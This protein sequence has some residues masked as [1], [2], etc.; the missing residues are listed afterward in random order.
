MSATIALP[1]RC[2]TS[3]APTLTSL[4]DGTENAKV[5]AAEVR[6]FG[7]LCLEVLCRAI[8]ARKDTNAEIAIDNI[9]D[10]FKTSLSTFGLSPEQLTTGDF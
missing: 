4:L 1:E 3:F 5:D 7:A 2:D 6:I 8:A 10:G 9:S